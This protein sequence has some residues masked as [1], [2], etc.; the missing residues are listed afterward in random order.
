MNT[1]MN[2]TALTPAP[3]ETTDAYDLFADEGGPQFGPLLKFNKGKFSLNDND[4]AIGTQFIALVHELRRGC[5]LFLGEGH[6][7]Y[8]IGL[9]RD[10][11]KFP[12]REEMGHTDKRQWERD[13]RSGE[14]R[15]P[16]Q[17]QYFLPLVHPE[18]DELC[19]FVTGSA[20]GEGAIRDLVRLYKPRKTTTEAPVISLQVGHYEHDK[21]G[22][23]AIPVFKHQGWSDLGFVPPAPK[24]ATA[25]SAPVEPPA[26][27]IVPP[28]V[29]TTKAIGKNEADNS[30][31]NGD[32]VPF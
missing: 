25:V 24:P 19:T 23:V 28:P 13:K 22:R 2:S 30:D 17:R 4:V 18:T 8:R 3:A 11:F 27:M 7:E 15:D 21:Y 10:G 16:C 14:P 1:L 6:V 31:M 29:A 26:S 9:V 32:D 12:T 20:G 5:V